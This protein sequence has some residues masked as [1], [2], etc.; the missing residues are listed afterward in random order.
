MTARR[1]ARSCAHVGGGISAASS[2]SLSLTNS[3]VLGN[4]STN[5]SANEVVGT[6]TYAGGDIVGTNVYSGNTYVGTTTAAAVFEAT[7]NNNGVDAGAL[8]DNGGP[9][10]TIALLA[11]TSN[12]ALDAGIAAT[13]SE[14]ARSVA[15]P[16]DISSVEDA[17]GGDGSDLSA[18]EVDV[19]GGSGPD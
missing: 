15:R 17:S 9:V 13:M 11:D 14:D 4:T 12:P 2:A 5:G 8:A 18:Y 7:S 1:P 19:D 16:T 10:Q 6:A 3:F